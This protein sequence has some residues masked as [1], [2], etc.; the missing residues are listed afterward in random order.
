[1]LIPRKRTAIKERRDRVAEKLRIE[2]Q[3][4]KMSAKKAQRLKKVRLAPC[5]QF[6]DLYNDSRLRSSEAGQNEEDQRVD[7]VLLSDY[8]LSVSRIAIVLFLCMIYVLSVSLC[9]L[10]SWPNE[11]RARIHRSS[12]S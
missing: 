10:E 3:A 4:A 7:I 1:M 2:Q 8:L 11:Q 12:T 9:L 6:P 5:P